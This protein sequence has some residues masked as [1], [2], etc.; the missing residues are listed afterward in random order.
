MEKIALITDSTCGLPN[1]YIEKYNVY[2]VSLKIIY[3]TKEFIDGIDITPDEVYSKIE[4]ELPTTSM[5]SV[6]DVSDTFEA[7]IK[8]GYTHVIAMPISSGLSGTINSFLIASEHFKDKLNCF[9]FDTKILSMAVGL[10]IIEIGKMI[11]AKKS[12]DYICNEIPRLRNKTSMYFTVDT[13]EYLLKGGRIGKVSGHLGQ[14]LNIKPIITMS[15]D[16]SYT[17][18]SKT[19][20][21]NQA[22]N[23]LVSIATDILDK[24]KCKVVIMT[25][26]MKNE[27]E[28]LKTILAAHRNT[29]FTYVGSITPVVGIHSGPRLLA[30][31]ILEE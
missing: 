6:Q 20:G 1:E 22:F 16:G 8:D 14:L 23:K 28:K 26:T 7:I 17:T 9:V 12:F 25:G 5:P 2:V 27:A 4:E 29:T 11:E 24:G 10:S 21:S 3:K 30:F 31:A 13:L 19:R 18:F 15:E